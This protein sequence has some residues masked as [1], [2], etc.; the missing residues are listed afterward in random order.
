M[1]YLLIFMI[2]FPC[3][4]LSVKGFTQQKRIEYGYNKNGDRITRKVIIFS[5]RVR[6]ADLS[7]GPHKD[8]PVVTDFFANREIRIFPNPTKGNIKIEVIFTGWE[9]E[10]NRDDQQK[11]D[12]FLYDSKGK[13][14]EQKQFAESTF[15][16]DLS[17]YPAGWYILQLCVGNSRKEYKIIKE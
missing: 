3:M 10:D 12:L 1:K 5:P 4:E 8:N 17:D 7:Q 13:Q 6:S 9:T 14:A 2:L 11:I 16:L 15:S